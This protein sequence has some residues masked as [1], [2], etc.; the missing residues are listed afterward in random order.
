MCCALLVSLAICHPASAENAASNPGEYLTLDPEAVTGESLG[1][2]TALLRSPVD[3]SFWIGM[4]D[5]GLLRIGRNGRRI[6]Y[7]SQSGHLPSDA[8]TGLSATSSGVIYILDESGRVT[9]Y[10]STEGF[11]PCSGLS[12]PVVSLCQATD[13]AGVYFLLE[14]GAVYYLAD[15]SSLPVSVADFRVSVSFLSVAPDG[16]LYALDSSR[17]R[18]LAFSDGKCTTLPPLPE[19]LNTFVLSSSG[20]LWAGSDKGIFRFSDRKWDFLDLQGILPSSRV[21][22]LYPD[23]GNRL[24]IA[25]GRGIC[26]LDVSKS[27]VSNS[28]VLFREETF[29]PSSI[30]ADHRVLYAGG[31]RG[32]AAISLDGS[33]SM[34]PWPLPEPEKPSRTG[35]FPGWLI[36]VVLPL[37]P[38]CYFLGRR[39]VSK[40]EPEVSNPKDNGKSVAV[41]PDHQP[42]DPLSD[43]P[44][45]STDSSIDTPPARPRSRRSAAS[46]A[47]SASSNSTLSPDE[48]FQLLDRLENSEQDSFVLSVYDI[49]KKSYSDSKLSVEDMAQQLGMTRVHVNRKLQAAQGISPSFLLKAYRMRLAASLLVKNEIP[50][51]EIA[52]KTGFSSSSYFSSAFKDF[53]GQSPSEYVASK[54]YLTTLK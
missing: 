22:S 5:K 27:N 43:H 23:A 28:E 20:T 46:K 45:S 16:T 51:S 42:A 37:L 29:L 18:V 38:L 50:V 19:I 24:W 4:A 40:P 7:T 9:R 47:D 34:E 39:Y 52:S 44:L 53:F 6:R 21:V 33:F 48:A 35:G 14:S 31:V 26:C 36:L 13:G 25:S 49:I 15:T 54:I 17:N 1:F 12:G 30:I 3:D 11:K 2:A 10:S 32:V 8:I 41:L